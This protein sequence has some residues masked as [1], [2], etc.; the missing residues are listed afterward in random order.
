MLKVKKNQNI[1]LTLRISGRGDA[2]LYLGKG[3][4]LPTVSNYYL[5]SRNFKNDE[6][7][8]PKVDSTEDEVVYTVGVKGI[9]KK[10]EFSLLAVSSDL[11]VQ[12]LV[13]GAIQTAE[14]GAETPLVLRTG[15]TLTAQSR[16]YFYSFDSLITAY[17]SNEKKGGVAASIPSMNNSLQQVSTSGLGVPKMFI[18]DEEMIKTKFPIRPELLIGF[19][20]S[21]MNG[22][23]HFFVFHPSIPIELKPSS[24]P[25][26]VQ[27][28]KDEEIRV[29][30]TTHEG[31]LNK[32][33]VLI[34][35]EPSSYTYEFDSL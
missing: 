30:M 5:T 25:L 17:L 21:Y 19:Y 4:S 32:L 7:S 8:I 29:I 34:G 10:A 9:S 12:N 3:N 15:W 24:P 35:G 18:I 22:T 1:L 23:V 33:T 13:F 31:E 6:L 11:K 20:P 16:L 26:R 2:D 28:K 27:L 14:I